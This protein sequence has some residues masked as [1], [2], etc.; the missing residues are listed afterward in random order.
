[1][2]QKSIPNKNFQD[3][4]CNSNVWAHSYHHTNNIVSA[5]KVQEKQISAINSKKDVSIKL[6]LK[7]WLEYLRE[8]AAKQSTIH[9]SIEKSSYHGIVEDFSVSFKCIFQIYVFSLPSDQL[10]IP[11]LPSTVCIK[12]SSIHYNK[13]LGA[14][15]SNGS[16][17]DED[18]CIGIYQDAHTLFCEKTGRFSVELNI[19]ANF[20]TPKKNGVGIATP[21]S[22]FNHLEIKVPRK[23]NIDVV[24]PAIRD[25]PDHIQ[26][27]E[28]DD[29]EQQ[30]TIKSCP[31]QPTT[32]LKIQWTELE[33]QQPKQDKIN[34]ID[35]GASTGTGSVNK[36]QLKPVLESTKVNVEQ[37]TLCSVG[38]GVV[39]LTTKIRYEVVSGSASSFD[40]LVGPNIKILSVDGLNIKR[41]ECMSPQLVEIQPE[42]S[43]D[44]L[45]KVQL[46]S[47]VETSYVLV[48]TSEITMESTS[49]TVIIPSIKTIGNEI[50]REKGYLA[51]ESNA[52]VEVEQISRDGL[53]LIDKTEL[54]GELEALTSGPILL[55]YK[56]LVPKYSVA[57]KIVKH[58]DL[59]VLV[60]ICQHAKFICTVSSEGATLYKLVFTIRNTQQQYIRI[61]IPHQYEI[62][63]TIVGSKAVK[64]AV[65][66]SGSLMIPLTKSGSDKGV[67][68]K[69]KVELVYKNSED[70]RFGDSGKLNL[71]FPQI[72][73]P[74]S[75]LQITT[76]LPSIYDYSLF[77]GNIKQVSFLTYHQQSSTEDDD[78]S[79]DMVIKPKLNQMTQMQQQF[80]NSNMIGGGG[81][82]G[83]LADNGTAGLKPVMVNIPTVGRN[84]NFEQLLVIST[85]I[86]ISTNYTPH[87]NSR[88]QIL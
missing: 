14:T 49:A 12:S 43:K 5:T 27:K 34:Q 29:V 28:F 39:V 2:A 30:H 42:T 72:D 9:Y 1:M 64:P 74:I 45:I 6:S 37:H 54:P 17:H 46:T 11:L 73:I 19:L 8:S 78:D 57:L 88:C 83:G 33:Q 20:L 58:N 76:Y 85:D 16:K 22:T 38:E 82:G 21:K 51:V 59:S 7:D 56:F 13:D 65:D 66:D 62:W 31:F 50:T 60:A 36:Q 70:I 40:I 15:E 79:D 81:G 53:T 61:T 24:E 44:Q 63:S 67:Q 87:K 18:S 71:V 3:L 55:S 77:K 41:W 68:K 4:Y 52:N 75:M 84:H 32:Y 10:Q 47:S 25:N 26:Y 35:L 86:Q 48:I 80:S 69:F 23:V